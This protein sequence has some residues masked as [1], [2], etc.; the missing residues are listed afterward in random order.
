MSLDY[1]TL[2][3]FQNSKWFWV[4]SFHCPVGKMICT[5][6]PTVSS[7]RPHV[8][9]RK[10]PDSHSIHNSLTL[11]A[12]SLLVLGFHAP[13]AKL[14]AYDESDLILAGLSSPFIKSH[15]SAWAIAESSAVLL[16][17][18]EAPMYPAASGSVITLPLISSITC[19]WPRPVPE[20]PDTIQTPQPAIVSFV[21]FLLS[22][23]DPS[24]YRWIRDMNQ[25]PMSALYSS[26]FRSLRLLLTQSDLHI[27][28]FPY[29]SSFMA[30]GVVSSS[31]LT[32]TT[33]PEIGAYISDTDFTDSMLAKASIDMTR[34]PT[35]GNSTQTTS[36]RA[37]HNR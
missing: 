31:S 17:P 18:T 8:L 2:T 37:S 28:P 1:L 27:H 36:V 24:T 29:G 35:I 19:P 7:V 14:D 10:G 5:F 11:Y 26:A 23:H 30:S 20:S 25:S 22:P 34:S 21:T 9:D 4:S 33:S 12:I 3:G 32:S 6:V 13:V 16:E 15:L